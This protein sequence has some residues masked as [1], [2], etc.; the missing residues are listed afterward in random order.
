M[1][2]G[3]A[4]KN[5]TLCY[6]LFIKKRLMRSAEWYVTLNVN[7]LHMEWRLLFLDMSNDY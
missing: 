5:H 6:K 3:L 2:T 7:Y 4:Y 1:S